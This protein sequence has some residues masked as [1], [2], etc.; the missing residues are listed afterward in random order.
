[1]CLPGWPQL[2]QPAL[3]VLPRVPRSPP[4]PP[5]R[6]PALCRQLIAEAVA[7]PAAL[8]ALMRD[9]YG[10]YV[11]Q[12]SVGVGWAGSAAASA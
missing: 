2:D 7:R 1:M 10:N 8:T 6:T 11:V 9:Q 12:A 5:A 4:S 3:S